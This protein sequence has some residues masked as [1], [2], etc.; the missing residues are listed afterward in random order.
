M[1][2]LLI[3]EDSIELATAL[4]EVFEK[5]HQITLAQDISSAK[6][7]LTKSN[8][9]LIIL[10]VTLPDG[11]GFDLFSELQK[12][13]KFKTPVIF[14]TGQ[15]DLENRMKGLEL[16]AQDY[17]LKPF[18]YKELVARVEMRLHQFAKL[19]NVMI[20]GDL[21]FETHEHRVFLIDENNTVSK[22]IDLTPKEYQILFL[23]A[24]NK[25]TI[26]HRNKIVDSVWGEGHSLSEKA[27]NSHISNI[28]K[29]VSSTQCKI[30]ASDGVG[31]ILKI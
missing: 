7:L 30:L 1:S 18:Y 14:L 13:K 25:D 21:K 19:S 11:S 4:N 16:G 22:S 31:Y 8:F 17:I 6:N 23:L 20:C 15:S 24:A 12:N 10:D 27:I 5:S 29:K 3:V 9:D 26:I 2:H 28:R